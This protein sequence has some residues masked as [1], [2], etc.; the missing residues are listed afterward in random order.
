MHIKWSLPAGS[1]LHRHPHTHNNT[2]SPTSG[3]LSQL[4]ALHILFLCLEPPSLFPPCELGPLLPDPAPGPF[5]G[6]SSGCLPTA[7]PPGAV[8]LSTLFFPFCRRSAG[9]SALSFPLSSLPDLGR[10]GAPHRQGQCL[11]LGDSRCLG[12]VLCLSQLLLWNFDQVTSSLG[13]SVSSSVQ[14]GCSRL[15]F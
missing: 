6:K 11:T 9:H 12:P 4:P 8:L 2:H 1:W 10:L 15:G 3:L 13:T 5:S 7:G 14:R